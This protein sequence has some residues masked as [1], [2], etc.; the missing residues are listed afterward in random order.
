MYF[1]HQH[2]HGKH[3]KHPFCDR[4]LP[5]LCDDMVDPEFGTGTPRPPVARKHTTMCA[6]W[7]KGKRKKKLSALKWR[8][9]TAHSL[10]RTFYFAESFDEARCFWNAS[11]VSLFHFVGT[12]LRIFVRKFFVHLR[13]VYATPQKLARPLSTALTTTSIRSN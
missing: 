13:T 10:R 2:L 7:W 9:Q 4:K 5:I 1:F 8:G 6:Y 12:H 11:F 3:A